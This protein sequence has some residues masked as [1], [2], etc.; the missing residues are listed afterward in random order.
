MYKPIKEKQICPNCKQEV[1][2]LQ[3]HDCFVKTEPIYPVNPE[4]KNLLLIS[5]INNFTRNCPRCRAELF[6]NFTFGLICRRCGYREKKKRS[7][8][9]PLPT[10]KVDNG[11]DD[12]RRL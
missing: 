8:I 1:D 9:P 7:G 2:N 11:L 6:P 3:L 4:P 5:D 10:F 12:L